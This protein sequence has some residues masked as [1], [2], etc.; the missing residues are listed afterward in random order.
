MNNP[1]FVSG[2][3]GVLVFIAIILMKRA[4]ADQPNRS[5][6]LKI[7]VVTSLLSMAA[8]HFYEQPMTPVMSEP[9][10]SS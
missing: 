4:N 10:I 1:Y 7:S 3:I 5:E 9:F 8:L 2:A 6:A